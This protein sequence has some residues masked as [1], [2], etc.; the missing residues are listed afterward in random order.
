[1][2]VDDPAFGPDQ[3]SENGVVRRL[4]PWDFHLLKLHD[5]LV[6][7]P[8]DFHGSVVQD[9][10]LLQLVT[11]LVLGQ[12][13]VVGGFLLR[14]SPLEAGNHA[15]VEAFGEVLAEAIEIFHFN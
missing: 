15:E 4:L 13:G 11:D 14:V 2:T 6:L 10:E 12:N 9:V 8:F 3:I 7:Q 5:V 1:L